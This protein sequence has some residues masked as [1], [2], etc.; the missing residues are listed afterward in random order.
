MNKQMGGNTRQAQTRWIYQW[1]MTDSGVQKY[2]NKEDFE[3]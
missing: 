3:S 1:A 2:M